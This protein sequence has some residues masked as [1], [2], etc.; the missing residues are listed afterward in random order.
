LDVLDVLFHVINIV[1][2]SS[3]GE[4]ISIAVISVANEAD[5]NIELSL[6]VVNNIVDNLLECI[7]CS[8]NPRAH[9]AGTIEEQS[10]FQKL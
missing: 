7:L 8:S 4:S 2:K 6:I 5:S 1:S 3:N 9:G 10:N